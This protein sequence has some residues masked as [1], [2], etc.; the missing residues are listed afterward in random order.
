MKRIFET[1]VPGKQGLAV[2][3]DPGQHL[4]VVD[5]EGRQ[6]VDMALFNLD[7][8]REK[9]ST[10][11]SRTR[12]VGRSPGTYVPRGATRGRRHASFDDLSSDDDHH[13][14]DRTREGRA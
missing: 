2:E 12:Y 10:S 1:L 7:N 13:R 3:L 5:V 4:R 8:L 9:L 6:V 11:Y 14:G